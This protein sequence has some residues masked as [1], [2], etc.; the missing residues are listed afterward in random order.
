MTGRVY[1]SHDVVFDE[2]IFPFSNLHPNAGHRLRNEILLLHASLRNHAFGKNCGDNNIFNISTADHSGADLNCVQETEPSGAH[3]T[4]NPVKS[5]SRSL[6]VDLC[7]ASNFPAQLRPGS[8]STGAPTPL[9][10]MCLH[11]SPL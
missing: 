8:S 4:E 10:A 9:V 5:T 2:T 1:I 11:P 6:L 7:T 3:V